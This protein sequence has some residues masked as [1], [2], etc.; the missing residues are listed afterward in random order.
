MNKVKKFNKE[1]SKIK[2]GWYDKDGRLHESLKTGNF[3]KNYRMQYIDEVKRH[4]SSI[5]WDLCEVEREFFKKTSYPFMTV[6]AVLK[7]YKRKPCHTFLVFKNNDKYYWFEASWNKMKG[8]REY[9]SLEKLFDDIRDNF[10]EFTKS[11]D[12]DKNEIEFYKYKKP[13]EKIG[14]N[15]FYIHCIYFGKKIKKDNKRLFK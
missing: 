4:K 15:G 5:C 10:D 12:Y 3:A 8:I 1:L 2:Y 13:R 11:K 14:C 9:N 6:F 7:K